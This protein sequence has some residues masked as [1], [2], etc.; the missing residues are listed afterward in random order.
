MCYTD[1]SEM[2]TPA[3]PPH[4][5][6]GYCACHVSQYATVHAPDA[7]LQLTKPAT[8]PDATPPKLTAGN[9][10]ANFLKLEKW[11]KNVQLCA[12]TV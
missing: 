7:L 6:P 1:M 2:H 8:A 11:L 3:G 10:C 4:A 12:Q 9:L 5:S